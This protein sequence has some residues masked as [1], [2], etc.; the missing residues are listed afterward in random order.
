MTA[1]LSVIIPLL[2]ERQTIASVI[3]ECY[4]LDREAEVVVIANGTTDGSEEIAR[5]SG[6][7]V[8]RY[9]HPLGHDVGRSIGARRSTGDILL[10]VDG[11]MVIP[12]AMLRPFVEQVRGGADIVLND[13]SGPVHVK[14]V[15]DVVLAKHV[16]NVALGRSDLRGM[17]LSAVPHAMRRSAAELIGYEHLAVPPLAHAMAVFHGL[18]IQAG[19]SVPVGK[20][21][22]RRSH[23]RNGDPT[24]RLMLGDHLEA[25]DWLLKQTGERGNRHDYGR[26][27][28]EVSG[29]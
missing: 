20:L 5:Q 15:H 23:R 28:N 21:N 25:L 22:P 4:A 14:H 9:D 29:S 24:G 12:S 3:R 16:L 27:R 17:S 8:I 2:N 13:Y 10:F 18:R 19:P 6:A 7:I 26:R 11:D 1:R